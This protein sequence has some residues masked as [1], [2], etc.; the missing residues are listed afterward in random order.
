MGAA[1]NTFLK[2]GVVVFLL[3][4]FALGLVNTPTVAKTVVPQTFFGV[5]EF[6][7]ERQFVYAERSLFD[8][9]YTLAFLKELKETNG[10]LDTLGIT[11][12]EAQM[13]TLKEI[14]RRK[15]AREKRDFLHDKLDRVRNEKMDVLGVTP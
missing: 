9:H 1:W 6:I 3:A 10:A 13:A 15:R 11:P 8:I 5:Q 12:E 4:V 14:A 7:N 2:A